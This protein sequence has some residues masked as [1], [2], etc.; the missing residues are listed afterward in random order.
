MYHVLEH[1]PRPVEVLKKLHSIAKTSTRLVI[2]VPILENGKTN[3]IN[4]FFS[5]QHMTH[6]SR[7]SLCSCLAIAGWEIIKDYE[8]ADY[9]GYRVLASRVVQQSVDKIRTVCFQ[10]DWA[11]LNAN[12]AFRYMAILEVEKVIQ[13]MQKCEK[14]VIW[15]GGAHTEYLYHVTS[16]F[17]AHHS[18]L[19]IIVDKD[20]IK[21]GK[22]W[23]GIYIYDSSILTKLDWSS[24]I[25]II[26]S[27]SGQASIVDSLEQLDVPDDKIVRLYKTVNRY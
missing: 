2:E 7:N 21:H 14:I 11:E 25:L 6:F 20:P 3:D 13:Q 27:Y 16:L 5:I 15:G 12:L 1:L 17:H 8:T 18:N 26:S 24:T 23:R 10:K 4:S 22:T 19:F 9:N